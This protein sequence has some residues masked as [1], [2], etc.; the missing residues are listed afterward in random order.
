MMMMEDLEKEIQEDTGKQLEAFK[1]ETK[2]KKKALESYR[3]TIPKRR[4]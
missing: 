3:K 4:N 1:E 2:K